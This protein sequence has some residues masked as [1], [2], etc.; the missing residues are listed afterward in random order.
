MNTEIPLTLAQRNQAEEGS[1]E[2]MGQREA[3]ARH[4]PQQA[5]EHRPRAPHHGTSCQAWGDS[6]KKLHHQP[7]MLI[8]GLISTTLCAVDSK[9]SPRGAHGCVPARLGTLS[10]PPARRR[11]HGQHGSVGQ[12]GQGAFAGWFGI[13]LSSFLTL[14]WRWWKPQLTGETLMRSEDRHIR[15]QLLFSVSPSFQLHDELLQ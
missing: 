5:G 12:W 8:S 14:P 11:A 1:N 15:V 7:S 2:V 10:L 4:L 3:P 13:H 6:S 9:P